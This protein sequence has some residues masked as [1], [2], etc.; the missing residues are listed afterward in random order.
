V[1]EAGREDRLA[2][3]GAGL[4]RSLGQRKARQLLTSL[5]KLN[6]DRQIT[7]GCPPTLTALV[8]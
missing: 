8:E 5:M 3:D 1:W 7:S 6:G 2:A 4:V